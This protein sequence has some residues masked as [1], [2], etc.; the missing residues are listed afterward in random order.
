MQV[1]S[2]KKALEGSIAP[3]TKGVPG[4]AQF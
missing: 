1:V 3:D 2:V 4:S